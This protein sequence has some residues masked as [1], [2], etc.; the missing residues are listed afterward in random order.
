MCWLL[1]LF[2]VC[3]CFEL[4]CLCSHVYNLFIFSEY[5][6]YVRR[7]QWVQSVVN[8]EP[9][10]ARSSAF[11]CTP[12]T[13]LSPLWIVNGLARTTM[14]DQYRRTVLHCTLNIEYWL[15]L[16]IVTGWFDFFWILLKVNLCFFINSSRHTSKFE[17]SHK[18]MKIRFCKEEKWVPHSKTLAQLTTCF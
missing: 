4:L 11:G 3:F 14:Y 13:N 15:P 8:V 1:L 5:V 6:T 12:T 18:Y 7:P 10:R 2:A 17:F 9:S 16:C